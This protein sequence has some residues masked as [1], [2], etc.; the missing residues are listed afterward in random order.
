[1]AFVNDSLQAHDATNL[2]GGF[3]CEVCGIE[4]LV[5]P[6]NRIGV[7]KYKEAVGAAELLC[8]CAG[9][10]DLIEVFGYANEF[11]GFKQVPIGKDRDEKDSLVLLHTSIL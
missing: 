10:V 7:T 2:S 1:M 8:Q 4:V 11:S 5:A 6:R 9:A 3:C